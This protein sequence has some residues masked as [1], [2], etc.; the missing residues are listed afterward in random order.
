MS[1]LSFRSAMWCRCLTCISWSA[2]VCSRATIPV[3]WFRS[4]PIS[5]GTKRGGSR[6]AMPSRTPTESCSTRRYGLPAPS[7]PRASRSMRL[8]SPSPRTRPRLP[9]AS[10]LRRSWRSSRCCR[11]PSCRRCSLRA[12]RRRCSPVASCGQSST[13]AVRK[14]VE[15]KRKLSAVRRIRNISAACSRAFRKRR[16]CSARYCRRTVF[17]SRN[18]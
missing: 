12:W 6:S 15:R 18:A 8:R 16:R 7:N 10:A 17:R 11:S 14:S 13:G 1:R 4:R 9:C 3:A 2:R 5:C